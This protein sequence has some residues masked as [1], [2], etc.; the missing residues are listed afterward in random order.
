MRVRV[1]PSAKE[2]CIRGILDDGS[3]KIDLKAPP[4]DGRAN[5]ELI[6]F[7]AEEL[8]AAKQSV[9]ILSGHTSR[10]KTVRILNS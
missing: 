10:K 5:E 9:E 3:I 2:N 6:E 4:E 8:H 7:L 1:R